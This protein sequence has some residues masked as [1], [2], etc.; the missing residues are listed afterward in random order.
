MYRR[1]VALIELI[2][3]VW[4]DLQRRARRVS[5]P[6]GR[7]QRVKEEEDEQLLRLPLFIPP[8]FLNLADGTARDAPDGLHARSASDPSFS[9]RVTEGSDGELK[10][11][12]GAPRRESAWEVQRGFQLHLAHLVAVQSRVEQ[13]LAA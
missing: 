11:C 5:A 7:A 8:P 4:Y 1:T 2:A 13:H 12:L 10:F 6:E 9:D 3:V